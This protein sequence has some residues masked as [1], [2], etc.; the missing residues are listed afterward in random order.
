MHYSTAL[1]LLHAPCTTVTARAQIPVGILRLFRTA[2][3]WQFESEREPH[4]GNRN[5]YIAR[6]KVSTFSNILAYWTS[7]A[8]CLFE[9]L[10]QCERTACRKC[11]GALCTSIC[12]LIQP[13][14]LKRLLISLHY[15]INKHQSC[16]TD[17]HSWRALRVLCQCTLL[18]TQVIGGSSCTNAMLFHRGSSS[19]YD[20]WGVLGWSAKDVLPY[21]RQVELCDA[22][23]LPFECC[24]RPLVQLDRQRS[25]CS[26]VN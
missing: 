13:G 14:L 8:V 7:K 5:I 20:N 4:A 6:G 10:C 17:I 12:M 9:C 19:D 18:D 21:F 2:F 25:I 22:T 26:F 16:V 3:D 23:N 11:I 1:T 24:A 15:L